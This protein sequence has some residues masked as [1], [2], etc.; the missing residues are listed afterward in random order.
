MAPRLCGGRAV[1]GGA[2]RA[3][4][5]DGVRRCADVLHPDHAPP[6]SKTDTHFT[7]LR[8]C[9]DETRSRAVE[10]VQVGH[11]VELSQKNLHPILPIELRAHTHILSALVALHCSSP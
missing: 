4:G 11:G 6:P 10:G 1:S 9:I 8:Q 7:V 2:R 3:W 5:D